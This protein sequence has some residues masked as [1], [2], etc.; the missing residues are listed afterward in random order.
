MQLQTAVDDFVVA[1][2]A[3]GLK[4]KTV[5]WYT[6]SLGTFI[7][8]H[9]D[10]AL[11]DFTTK[12]LR[13]YI[14]DL[15]DRKWQWNGSQHIRQDL[16]LSDD[17]IN[18]HIRVLH[19]FWAWCSTEYKMPNPMAAIRYPRKP[20]AKPKAIPLDDVRTLFAATERSRAAARDRAILAFLLDTGC[21]AAGLVGLK[22]EDL[23]VE[24]RKAVVTEK[25]S[26]TRSVYFTQVTGD[27]L[28]IWI[29]EREESAP[30]LFYNLDTLEPLTVYGLRH[31]LKRLAKRAGVTGR[32]NPHSFRHSFAREYL[33]AGG[34]LS[35]LS[36]LMGH[37]DVSTT[38]Q[39]YAIF[40]QDEVREA[41][42]KYS[43]ARLLG[44][45]KKSAPPSEDEAL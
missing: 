39:H 43:P 19:R 2:K 32:V 40:D 18:A 10:T 5:Q 44:E 8:A 4:R 30:H 38:V 9:S 35:T 3:D 1:L 7:S 24:Q 41:H 14:A 22:P 45:E 16:P 11:D 13:Q 42:E 17:T 25:G 31:M 26:K 20:E 23:N 6:W 28:A 37:R 29:G 21:R 36:R 33:R 34:D 27:L 12:V 15:R